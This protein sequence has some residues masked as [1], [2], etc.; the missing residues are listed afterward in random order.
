M[1]RTMRRNKQQMEPSDCIE[2]LKQEPRGV[3]SMIG[4]DR[5]YAMMIILTAFP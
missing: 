3:L 5:Q 4:D 1:F 2:L